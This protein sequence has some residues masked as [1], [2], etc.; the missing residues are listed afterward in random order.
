MSSF[1]L[2][3][4]C[5]LLFRGLTYLSFITLKKITVFKV[6]SPAVEFT[7]IT[8][9]RISFTRDNFYTTLFCTVSVTFR[10]Y[11]YCLRQDSA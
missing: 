4:Y 7:N 5:I 10:S 6:V 9:L 8:L 3:S 1:L 11:L 2:I